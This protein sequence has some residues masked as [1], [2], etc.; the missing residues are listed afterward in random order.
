[1]KLFFT[2]SQI[3]KD[4]KR[5]AKEHAG[6]TR[7]LSVM[8]DTVF[9]A[10]LGSDTVES[11][12][13]LRLLLCACT[14]R[15]VSNVRVLNSNLT[16]VHLEGKTARLDVHVTFND[17]ECADLEMQ[18]GRSSD[19]L[20]KRAAVYSAMM[21]AGQ[22]KRGDPY[23]EVKRVYQIFF[24]NCILF[25]DSP[26]L[27]RRY[28][29][30]EEGEHDQ[31][32]EVS[33]IIFYELPKLEQRVLDYLAG[34]SGIETLADDEK[35]CIFMRYRHEEHVSELI[36]R[37]CCE[38]EGIMFA[39]KAVSKVDR[40]MERYARKMAAIKNS[41]D[42]A[43][44][45]YDAREEGLQLG[46]EEG[47]QLGREEGIQQGRQEGQQEGRQEGNA[48]GEQ[49]IQQYVLQLIAQGLTTEEIKQHLENRE[50]EAG[51]RE[52]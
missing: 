22:T 51:G 24:L 17:G 27:P 52:Q 50:Q 48:Q 31:L 12:E 23:R 8:D 15:Q 44:M 33:E 13:A 35:W 36:K 3:D 47:L 28:S 41:M 5:L 11:R 20:K 6:N 21:L 2:R 42:R 45:L 25:P 29:Y 16:P 34:R 46:R 40:S 30:R 7:P 37:L 26:K 14:R 1:M 43:Q 19:D 32:T 9:K 38:E 4:L 10:M 49:K 18:V 39:N